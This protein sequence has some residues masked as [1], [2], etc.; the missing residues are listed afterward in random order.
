MLVIVLVNGLAPSLGEVVELT[1]HFVTSGHVA[2][3]ESDEKDL[4][5]LGEEHG[6]GPT[7]HLCGCCHSQPTL[8]EVHAPMVLAQVTPPQAPGVEESPADG[9]QMRLLRPPIAA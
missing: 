5:A 1:A 2:H 4:G 8:P 3:F 9:A 6:C 7:A